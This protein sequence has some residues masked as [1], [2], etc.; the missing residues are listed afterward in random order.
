MINILFCGDFVSQEPKTIFVDSQLKS[1]FA[2]QDFV[3]INFEAPVRGF[4]NPINKSGPSLTQSTDSPPFLESLGV[5]IIQMA[6]NHMMDQNKDG[7]EASMLLFKK[8]N[9]IGAGRFNDAYKLSVIEKDGISVGL[10][11][12]THKEFGTLGIESKQNDYGTAW[13][14][15]PK[16]NQIILQAKK[17][18]DVLIALPH[19]GLEDVL[20]PLP[21]WR[22]RYKELIDL[23]ADVVIASH[24]HTPQGWEEYNDKII[25][26]SLG[27]LFFQLFNSQHGENWHKGLMVQMNIDNNH[28]LSYEII[29]TKFTDKSLYIDTST[30]IKQYNN[31]LCDLLQNDEKYWA[32]LNNSLLTLW[33]E[34]KLYLLR[35]LAAISLQK[36]FHMLFHAAYGLLKGPNIP[37]MLNN[38]QCESHRWAI[39]R[40][41]NLQEKNRKIIK[42]CST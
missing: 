17:V 25:Y 33:P 14:N 8:A 31:Y 11:C 24:P 22:C 21:E 19:A 10:L 28:I 37:M 35:G 42:S 2:K 12:F 34:Y 39:E 9:V 29:N 32:Y 40:M 26:Y 41:L 36:N 5:N 23:G 16:V 38:F 7:C 30:E 13:I 15:H 1:L 3:S 6:N 27:N 4:G 18:C 20:V